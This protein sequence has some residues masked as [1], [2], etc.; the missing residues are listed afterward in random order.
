M[1][2]AIYIPRLKVQ[3]DVSSDCLQSPLNAL[4]P[5]SGLRLH[6]RGAQLSYNLEEDFICRSCTVREL[7]G[8]KVRK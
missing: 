5:V 2:N 1:K 6:V 3:A 4:V 8:S 7:P